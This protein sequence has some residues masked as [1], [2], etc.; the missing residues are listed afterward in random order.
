MPG[1]RNDL[2]TVP[3]VLEILADVSAHTDDRL[4]SIRDIRIIFG[5]GRTAAYELTHRP[6][7]PEPV[8]VSPRCYRWWASEVNAFAA[9]LRARSPKPASRARTQRAAI[10][11]LPHSEAPRHITGQIRTARTPK[12]VS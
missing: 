11:Q 6:E 8:R 7:F 1:H 12:A 2:L 3:Q 10:S 4:I 5:L 9:S